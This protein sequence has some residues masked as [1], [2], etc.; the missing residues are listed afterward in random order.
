MVRVEELTDLGRAAAKVSGELHVAIPDLRQTRER[1]WDVALHL[2]AHGVQ[3]YTDAIEVTTRGDDT[4]DASGFFTFGPA[5]RG[6]SKGAKR[7]YEVPS[8]EHGAIM[9]S[10]GRD[11]K[12]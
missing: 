7:R 12:T 10:A 4:G 2:R 9:L 11:G 5:Y 3:L 1:A 6:A 8:S